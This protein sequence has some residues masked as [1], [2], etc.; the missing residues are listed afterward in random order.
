MLNVDEERKFERG[1]RNDEDK[2]SL[3]S[4]SQAPG[5]IGV[6]GAFKNT[7]M[8]ELVKQSKEFDE[9]VY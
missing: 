4:F 1:K 8:E 2:M 9:R 7:E 3:S 5:M 6:P